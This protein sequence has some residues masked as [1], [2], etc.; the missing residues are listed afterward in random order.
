M[1][2][3]QEWLNENYLLENRN[4]ITILT[5]GNKN[6]EGELDLSDFINL[7][8][9][10]CSHNHL[11]SLEINNCYNLREIK[12]YKNKLNRLDLSQLT[13]LEKLDCPYNQLIILNVNNCSQLKNLRCGC[14]Q[15]IKL[16]ITSL[17]RL[18]KLSCNNNYIE[19]LDYSGLNPTK[20][21]YLSIG[22]NNLNVAGS[23]G[24]NDFSKFTNLEGLWIGNSEEKR[25]KKNIYN[26]FHGSLELLQNLSDLK[27]LDIDNTDIREGVEYLPKSI[28]EIC[29]TEG[30]LGSEIKEI[31]KKLQKFARLKSISKYVATNNAQQFLNERYLKEENLENLKFYGNDLT[32]LN[33]SNCPKLKTIHCSR[34]SNL[35]NLN[36]NKCLEIVKLECN[37]NNL[38]KLDFLNGLASEKLESLD[39]S[40]NNI[41]S[42][43]LLLFNRFNNLK[44]L[45]LGNY[46]EARIKK[47]VYNRFTGS[48]KFLEDL[49]E[50]EQLFIANTDIE[51]VQEQLRK[52]GEPKGDN[53]AK[54][55]IKNES[56][57]LEPKEKERLQQEIND[58]KRRVGEAKQKKVKAKEQLREAEKILAESKG[59]L[60]AKQEEI[61]HSRERLTVPTQMNITN[62]VNTGI[63][64]SSLPQ[65]EAPSQMGHYLLEALK[66]NLVDYFV[67]TG[68]YKKDR[69]AEPNIDG[70]LGGDPR[71]I[72]K[73]YKSFAKFPNTKFKINSPIN[74]DQGEIQLSRPE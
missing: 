67:I 38:A 40:D 49:P 58:L 74:T 4:K 41:Q 50:L 35:T 20:M 3:A 12:C 6:L 61:K 63:G 13:N 44:S 36:I 26:R 54:E 24:L 29:Y 23:Q 1:V 62:T 16:D 37:L 33:I 65:I 55:T 34:N 15:L 73:F 45:K 68:N 2:N 52:I 32:D 28:R 59:E 30:K 17:S 70:T 72:K 53:F 8:E 27:I 56:Q 14:N 5:I 11:V 7:R 46:D 42:N 48:L 22:N 18:K 64:P 31:V 19:N 51:E 25:I 21:I 43:D 39:L 57:E 60:K 66:E 69:H 10:D 47:G 9:L 71:K